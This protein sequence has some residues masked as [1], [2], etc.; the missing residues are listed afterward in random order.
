MD[1]TIINEQERKMWRMIDRRHWPNMLPSRYRRGGD[2]RR[3]TVSSE[4]D[5]HEALIHNLSYR[6]TKTDPLGPVVS[7]KDW[8]AALNAYS[9]CWMQEQGLTT[10]R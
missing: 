6:P 3:A 7:S 4:S 8:I 10:R 9:R 5:D 1:R 2:D